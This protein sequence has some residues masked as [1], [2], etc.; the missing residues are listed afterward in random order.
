MVEVGYKDFVSETF[1][2][3]SAP[4]ATPKEI[5]A[6][7]EKATL[8]ALAD[9]KIR[10]RLLKSGFNIEAK[11]GK[12]HMARIVKEIPMWRDIINQAGIKRG[13]K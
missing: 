1:T 3:L 7:L 2:A 13:K 10:E 6:R 5:V 4:A 12:G 11:D 9:P 8:Q